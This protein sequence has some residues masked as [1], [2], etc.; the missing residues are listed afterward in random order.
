MTD[1]TLDL[2]DRAAFDHWVV[3]TIRF[4]DQ[5]AA[6]HVNNVAFAAYVE[7]GRVNYLYDRLSDSIRDLERGFVLVRIDLTYRKQMHFPGSVEVGS[8]TLRLGRSSLTTGHG[9]FQG[10]DC[11]ATAECV[12]AYIDRRAG[13]AAAMPESVRGAFSSG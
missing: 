9:I 5:D 4:S 7:T 3:D 12:L 1:T 6:G 11:T 8:C 10:G 13:R 2:S